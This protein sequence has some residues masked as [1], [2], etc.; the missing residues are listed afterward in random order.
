MITI[1]IKH[2]A[3]AIQKLAFYENRVDILKVSPDDSQS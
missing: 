1:K 2:E 3:D